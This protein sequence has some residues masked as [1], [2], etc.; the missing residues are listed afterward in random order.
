MKKDIYIPV[1]KNLHLAIVPLEDDVWDLYLINQNLNTLK[2]IL[3]TTDASKDQVKSSTLRYFLESMDE[4]AFIKFESVLGNVIE[5]DNSVFVTYYIGA[6]IFD[7]TF[8]FSRESLL[9][10]PKVEIPIL[11]LEG[12]LL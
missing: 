7:I 12:Y 10:I 8:S 3:I 2:N 5:M 11:K 1:S 4:M 9:N 6:D